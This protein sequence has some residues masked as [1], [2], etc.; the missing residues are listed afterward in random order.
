VDLSRFDCGTIHVRPST[1]TAIGNSGSSSSIPAFLFAAWAAPSSAVSLT[2]VFIA[3]AGVVQVLPPAVVAATNAAVGRI[4]SA[5]AA[6]AAA[7]TSTSTFTP[8][9]GRNVS[10]SAANRHCHESNRKR[11]QHCCIEDLL[12]DGWQK[13]LS[14]AV[15]R[16]KKEDWGCCC[17]LASVK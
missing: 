10:T 13:K 1:I 2:V 7:S 15:T 8:E 16:W 12:D 6:S 5:V 3:A 11:H 9:M 4:C 17:K 14:F